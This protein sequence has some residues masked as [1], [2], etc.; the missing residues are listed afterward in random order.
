MIWGHPRQAQP[1]RVQRVSF[2][3]A[4]VYILF[5]KD[6][7]IKISPSMIQGDKD[8]LGHPQQPRQAQPLGVQQ[9]PVMFT[10]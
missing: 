7:L 8:A 5:F 2:D 6:K 3:M 1:W 10:C 4:H 9:V